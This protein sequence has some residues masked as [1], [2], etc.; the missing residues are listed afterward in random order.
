MSLGAVCGT[1]TGAVLLDLW[2]TR[3][4]FVVDL[5][6]AELSVKPEGW[7][8]LDQKHSDYAN[9]IRRFGTD[10]SSKTGPLPL[11]PENLRNSRTSLILK[12]ESEWRA[13]VIT[14]APA[15][16]QNIDL[17]NAELIGTFAVR[18]DFTNTKL[19]GARIIRSAMDYGQF[20]GANFE[21]ATIRQSQFVEANLTWANMRSAILEGANFERARLIGADLTGARL[22]GGQFNQTNL[23]GANFSGATFN[24]AQ[25]ETQR[26]VVGNQIDL[27]RARFG[28]VSVFMNGNRITVPTIFAGAD[29][30]GALILPEQIV[31]TCGDE[32]TKLPSNVTSIPHCRDVIG[33]WPL[34][35]LVTSFL[36]TTGN[37]NEADREEG[38]LK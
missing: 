4:W 8:P 23:S 20:S 38:A 12:V 17:R 27:R 9:V 2:P 3:N 34:P 6:R 32:G 37:S 35:R 10:E 5:N 16:L 11:N 30:T 31:L 1:V 26:A 14:V 36:E 7:F 15:Q 28:T 21:R 25:N 33:N 13:K 29:L 19:S 24:V 22:L 18:S